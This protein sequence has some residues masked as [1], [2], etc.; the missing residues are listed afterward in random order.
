M[1]IHIYLLKD[2]AAQC[3]TR[4]SEAG[5]L[6][7]QSATFQR[8]MSANAHSKT[9]T[10]QQNSKRTSSPDLFPAAQQY[11]SP[12]PQKLQININ[13]NEDLC[14]F[15]DKAKYVHILVIALQHL[16]MGNWSSISLIVL[17]FWCMAISMSWLKIK[18]Q[19]PKFPSACIRE[20][21][22]AMVYSH[23]STPRYI[24]CCS[25]KSPNP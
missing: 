25:G 10:F 2:L 14:R 11:M 16:L 8:H 13:Q 15:Q 7:F 5:L 12:R 22:N 17:C 20:G 19:H 9:W 6:T 21:V 1:W 3:M 23:D 4:L 18:G 24:P